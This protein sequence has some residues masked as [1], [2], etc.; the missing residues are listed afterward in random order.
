MNRFVASCVP[1]CLLLLPLLAVAD[2]NGPPRG[3]SESSTILDTIVVTGSYIR[4]ADTESPSPVTVLNSDEIV[5]L[6]FNS[7]ADAIRSV[8]AD[9]SGTLTQAF[10]GAMAG[11]SPG[12][13]LIAINGYKWSKELLHDT[14]S[15]SADPS[16][17][18]TFLVQKDDMFKTLTLEYSGGERYPNLLRRPQKEDVLAKIAHPR[19]AP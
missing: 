18:I 17:E 12:S 4:R 11:A 7:L 10:S 8:T 16:G 14:L 3:S 15:A 2:T 13:R 9:S 5:K 19:T 6:G 1:A